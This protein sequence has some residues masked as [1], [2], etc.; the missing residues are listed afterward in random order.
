VV[1]GGRGVGV[2]LQAFVVGAEK[3]RRESEQVHSVS[4]SS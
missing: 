1:D 3:V 4:R 2:Q